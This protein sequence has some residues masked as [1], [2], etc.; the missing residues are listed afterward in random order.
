MEWAQIA[1]SI[2]GILFVPLIGALIWLV[3]NIATL[4]QQVKDLKERD[5]EAAEKLEKI[6][7]NIDK[8]LAN[9]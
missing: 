7:D 6:R 3:A 1:V 2:I 4:K 8:W 9:G 5:S